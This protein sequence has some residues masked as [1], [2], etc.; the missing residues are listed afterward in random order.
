VSRSGMSPGG[1]DPATR[2]GWGP[3]GPLGRILRSGS[4]MSLR[5]RREP[6]GGNPGSGSGGTRWARRPSTTPL[7]K[8][9]AGQRESSAGESLLPPVDGRAGRHGGWGLGGGVASSPN[10]LRGA[11]RVAACLRQRG[12]RG[13]SVVGGRGPLKAVGIRLRSLPRCV[14]SSEPSVSDAYPG[15]RASSPGELGALPRSCLWGGRVYPGWWAAAGSGINL[16]WVVP[17]RGVRVRTWRTSYYIASSPGWT[18]VWW[19]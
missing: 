8:R 7:P 11:L 1:L 2:A 9:V 6:P 13:A 15:T 17:I 12:R 14:R 3:A 4:A 10:T 16:Q 5:C 19:K 18:P